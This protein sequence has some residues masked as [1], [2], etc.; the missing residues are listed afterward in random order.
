MCPANS[1]APPFVPRF[2]P[3]EVVEIEPQS[4]ANVFGT[5]LVAGSLSQFVP[6]LSR[7]RWWHKV[8]ARQMRH[9]SL[10]FLE[11]IVNT[12]SPSGFEQ[13]VAALYRD[14]VGP[15]AHRVTTDVLGNVT[16]I[17]TPTLPCVSCSPA[18]W[19]R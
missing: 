19:T 1:E 8:R 2:F 18:T 15:F 5:K 14:Y 11:S 4:V 3:S 6:P 10:T 7:N 13:P 9:E 12:A 16:A 17:I